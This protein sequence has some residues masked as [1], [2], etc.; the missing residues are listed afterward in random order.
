MRR[1]AQL[2]A[3]ATPWAASG[4]VPP[5]PAAPV[6]EEVPE[7]ATGSNGVSTGLSVGGR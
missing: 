7:P 1:S 3:P 5:H 2:V 6:A 4:A